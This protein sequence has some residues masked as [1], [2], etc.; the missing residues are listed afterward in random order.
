MILIICN[1]NLYFVKS[2]NKFTSEP[3]NG[4]IIIFLFCFN[5]PYLIWLKMLLLLNLYL[6][7][8]YVQNTKDNAK[9]DNTLQAWGAKV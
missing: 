8:I 2:A 1:Y 6:F 5:T 3:I 9:K 7:I 4:H